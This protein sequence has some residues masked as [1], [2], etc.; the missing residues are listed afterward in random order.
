MAFLSKRTVAIAA[1]V[2]AYVGGIALS[3][4][5][6]VQSD[7]VTAWAQDHGLVASEL[8]HFMLIAGQVLSWCAAWTAGIVGY[9]LIELKK[10]LARRPT[11]SVTRGQ[12]FWIVGGLLLG[13]AGMVIPDLIA[14]YVRHSAVG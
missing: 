1:L 14:D 6:H 13:L 5:A 7:A 3:T 8:F 2:G 9:R 10:S 4:V 11:G 12:V